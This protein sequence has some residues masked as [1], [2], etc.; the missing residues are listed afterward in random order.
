MRSRSRGTPANAE[1]WNQM[2][3]RIKCVGNIGS[4][5]YLAT[6]SFN[7]VRVV[8]ACQ[9]QVR[10]YTTTTVPRSRYHYKYYEIRYLG[11][12]YGM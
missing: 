1:G 3:R 7:V 12:T 10:M 4:M 2:S 9:V 5:G 11:C 6:Y 8:E